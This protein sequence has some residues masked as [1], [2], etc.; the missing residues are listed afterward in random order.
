MAVAGWSWIGDSWVGVAA[1][2]WSWV[3][4]AGAARSAVTWSSRLHIAAT[5]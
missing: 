4:V 2:G 1:A 3:G 5:V